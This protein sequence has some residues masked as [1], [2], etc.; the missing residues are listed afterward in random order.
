MS[1]VM[2]FSRVV[3]LIAATLLAGCSR[4]APPPASEAPRLVV[5]SPAIGL[6]VTELGYGDRIVGRHGYDGFLPSSIPVCGDQAGID[7]ERLLQLRPTHVL[8][9]WGSRD[10]PPRLLE[11]GAANGWRLDDFRLLTLDDART[12]VESID[13]LLRPAGVT[14]SANLRAIRDRMRAAWSKRSGLPQG[15]VLL[16]ASLS[17]IAAFGPGSCH[18]EVLEAIGGVPAMTN[19]AAY[20]S[21]DHE[22]VAKL[23]PDVFILLAP[24]EA[25]SSPGESHVRILT[26]FAQGL[27]LPPGM[28]ER[29]TRVIDD[30]QCQIPGVPMIRLADELEQAIR[31]ASGGPT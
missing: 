24:R 31:E 8:T 4:E 16:L 19:A 29:N 6:A 30:P 20:V 13:G 12:C 1:L 22:D 5:L 3:S 25:A 10:R 28:T 11:L 2:R 9:Q 27:R 23:A 14:E 15:R 21:L 26:S 18:H 17:P 7:Y